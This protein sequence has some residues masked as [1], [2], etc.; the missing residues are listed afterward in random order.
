[1]PG[2]E[3]LE[4]LSKSRGRWGFQALADIREPFRLL[5]ET[6]IPELRDHPSMAM[7][8]KT[9][10]D[11]LGDS[12]PGFFD[13]GPFAFLTKR[14]TSGRRG[15]I[16]A[17]A[18]TKKL[19]KMLGKDFAS[20][21]RKS[22]SNENLPLLHTNPVT[23]LIADAVGHG[24]SYCLI[25]SAE[26]GRVWAPVSPLRS[27][28]C[29]LVPCARAVGQLRGYGIPDER[30]YLTGLP[31]PR[32][33][34]GGENLEILKQDL[35]QRLHY[36]DPKERFWPVHGRNVKF[37]ITEEFAHFR[38]ER[39]LTVTFV[40]REGDRS[41]EIAAKA[42]QSF[43]PALGEGRLRVFITAGDDAAALAAFRESCKEAGISELPKGCAVIMDPNFA[44]FSERFSDAL[45][46]TDILWAPSAELAFA[47]G[48][49][50][51]F[52]MMPPRSRSETENRKWL[53]ET[54]VGV[55]QDDPSTA[56]EWINGLLDNG[57]LAEAAWGGFLKERK[58]G[59]YKIEEVL[60]TGT[61]VRES[62]PLRR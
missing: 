16:P 24:L 18:A 50:I 36:L 55:V 20:G 38:K 39:S 19:A 42:L 28:T 31:Y 22:L 7:F 33:V 25:S 41:P 40:I 57:S 13:S 15:K 58:F 32:K 3:V 45:R 30:I 10:S 2:G 11:S 52:V 60:R 59:L 35:G 47:G 8:R 54:Q 49:G 44:L 21:L 1:M 53:L 46:E 56:W 51:P 4:I 26:A 61:M 5:D 48:L 17:D 23:A 14:G 34:L 12:P 37:F 29:Y 6:G 62:S 43:L 9:L 27:K